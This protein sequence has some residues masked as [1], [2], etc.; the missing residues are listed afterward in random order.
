MADGNSGI[1]SYKSSAPTGTAHSRVQVAS[2]KAITPRVAPADFGMAL[3]PAAAANDSSASGYAAGTISG[4]AG[5]LATGLIY[6]PLPETRDLV[7]LSFLMAKYAASAYAASNGLTTDIGVFLVYEIC[8]Q[9]GLI[10]TELEHVCNATLTAG[11]GQ[12]AGSSLLNAAAYYVSGI[13]IGVDNSISPGVRLT[14]QPAA[15]NNGAAW[16]NFDSKGAVGV[17]IS[18][19]LGGGST[20]RFLGVRRKQV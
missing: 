17:L 2:D 5:Q 12:P 14:G 15:G 3:V 6:V 10:E 9:N 20:D 11:T 18:C 4:L 8:G 16:M 13:S 1:G 19:G 7:C